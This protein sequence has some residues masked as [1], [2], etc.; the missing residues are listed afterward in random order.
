MHLRYIYKQFC[1]GC[2]WALGGISLTALNTQWAVREAN[3]GPAYCKDLTG[4]AAGLKQGFVQDE[5]AVVSSTWSGLGGRGWH[6]HCWG[7][8]GW[9]CRAELGGRAAHL[10]RV[11]QGSTAHRQHG[12]HATQRQGSGCCRDTSLLPV[13][14]A[15]AAAGILSS[16]LLVPQVVPK[17]YQV[18]DPVVVFQIEQIL[19]IWLS[20][21]YGICFFLNPKNHQNQQNSME[22]YIP[23]PFLKLG[24]CRQQPSGK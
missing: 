6:P 1:V 11:S 22:T 24:T 16:T 2:H 10:A 8:R 19:W 5:A 7:G 12:G 14:A 23:I 18:Y 13:A 3:R 4:R 15:P 17:C 9:W 20:G 21:N